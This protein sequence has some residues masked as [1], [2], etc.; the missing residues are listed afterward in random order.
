MCQRV[1]EKL[2]KLFMCVALKCMQEL[3]EKT[4]GIAE[5]IKKLSE[6]LEKAAGMSSYP[7]S[8]QRDEILS[9]KP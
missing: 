6:E 1:Y 3:A 4:R 9:N 2:N 5:E 7:P 8:A